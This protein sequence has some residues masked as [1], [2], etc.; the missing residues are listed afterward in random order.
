MS[1][2]INL[3]PTI[4]TTANIGP[5]G[6]DETIDFLF[7]CSEDWA[8]EFEFV[9]YNSTAKN[10]EIKP[11]GALSVVDDLMTLSMKAPT[12]GIEVGTHYYEIFNLTKKRVYFK[13]S[14]NIVK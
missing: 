9:V 11:A 10:T 6:Y 14:L 12:Q 1:K 3:D 5:I 4:A 2:T 8:D 7:K 13:G